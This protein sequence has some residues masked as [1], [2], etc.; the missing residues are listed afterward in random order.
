MYERKRM[1][2]WRTTPY[3]S[4]LNN[5]LKQVYMQRFVKVTQQVPNRGFQSPANQN[6]NLKENTF[7]LSKSVDESVCQAKV[8]SWSLTADYADRTQ[9]TKHVFYICEIEIF[10]KHHKILLL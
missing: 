10:S 1:T 2:D 4:V 9:T 6:L 7:D 5:F 8:K 3:I